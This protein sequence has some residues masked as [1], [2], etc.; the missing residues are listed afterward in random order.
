M[1]TSRNR[2]RHNPNRFANAPR[3]GLQNA[4]FIV[5]LDAQQKENLS[6]WVF[7]YLSHIPSHEKRQLMREL[8]RDDLKEICQRAQPGIASPQHLTEA[9]KLALI[10][11]AIP[12]LDQHLVSNYL[13]ALKSDLEKHFGIGS[14]ETPTDAQFFDFI[15]YLRS[16][17]SRAAVNALISNV[18][19][20]P[21]PAQGYAVEEMEK[22]EKIRESGNEANLGEIEFP[23]MA[24][25]LG[26][27]EI[28]SVGDEKLESD[29]N[30]NDVNVESVE[31]IAQPEHIED[32]N[33]ENSTN[34]VVSEFEE[35]QSI[36]EVN[37]PLV[38]EVEV[39]DI[40]DLIYTPLG[41]LLISQAI[42]SADGRQLGA[43]SPED[44]ALMLEEFASLN[45]NH[46]PT[47]FQAGFSSA[48]G[49]V[50]KDFLIDSKAT[51]DWRKQY[52]LWGYIKG[53]SRANRTT[54]IREICQT[55]W[56][57]IIEMFRL[58]IG[59][60]LFEDVAREVIYANLDY[61]EELL[62]LSHRGSIRTVEHEINL[63]QMLD[64]ESVKMLRNSEAPRAAAILR[65]AERRLK[66]IL[67]QPDLTPAL[68]RAVSNLGLGLRMGLAASYR[69]VGDFANA[70]QVLSQT[71]DEQL[72]LSA[73]RNQSRYFIQRALTESDTKRIE[74][75]LLPRTTQERIAFARRFEPVLGHIDRAVKSTH[76]NPDARYLY[77]GIALAKEDYE[78]ASSLLGQTRLGYE[79]R[80]D[81]QLLIPQLRLQ[82]AILNF[83]LQNYSGI[84]ESINELINN[85][86]SWKLRAEEASLIVRV[87]LETMPNELPRLLDWLTSQPDGAALLTK[88]ELERVFQSLPS[89]SKQVARL[90][91]RI[92]NQVDRLAILLPI[93]EDALIRSH[94]EDL[95]FIL[96]EI[97]ELRNRQ[98]TEAHRM[99]A[100]F[101]R[102]NKYFRDY[103]G[104]FEAN[105]SAIS[106]LSLIPD[107][108]DLV[109]VL[110]SVLD[111]MLPITNFED[112]A[113]FSQLLSQLSSVAPEY[114]NI[115]EEDPRAAAPA[116][117]T[118]WEKSQAASDARESTPV[119]ILFVGGNPERQSE[120]NTNARSEIESKF[121][122]KVELD[123][124]IPGWGS[125]WM[126]V[127]QRIEQ[128][129]SK[130]DAVVLMPL[131]RT[132]FGQTL[133]RKL[134]DAHVPRIS[135]TAEGKTSSVR[136]IEEAVNIAR[137]LR[138]E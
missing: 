10:E 31:E 50:P 73:S 104:K 62:S 116:T 126:D 63:L 29:L 109:Q 24:D 33:F 21:V 131:T 60:D 124:Q 7:E 45:T 129:L 3:Q 2:P 103:L 79:D 136:A 91:H 55:E 125:N 112:E 102:S 30:A 5:E 78:G 68:T 110:I 12:K 41:R 38:D 53:L 19:L 37:D 75:V 80:D 61:A 16:H 81:R 58:N 111:E 54:E 42:S 113:N 14:I 64:T 11:Q 97:D 105:V 34:H 94:A 106:S 51:N 28:V 56:P 99:W 40:S 138:G 120:I 82:Q 98:S 35:I 90:S 48:L 89:C 32:D 59:I 87:T 96:G 133:R 22:I 65:L 6:R 15:T 108:S 23:L 114:V 115:Y 67:A 1:S 93:L 77:A 86:Y 100:E 83:H 69:I 72:S 76:P 85:P 46:R 74:D 118:R 101:C 57:L 8:T 39:P 121:G 36:I 119:R 128:K 43:L 84:Y 9:R 117:Y 26:A 25:S 134:N 123:F 4:D 107:T 130:V 132:T 20:S 135:C 47:W 27:P 49:L 122:S 127:I 44:Y 88:N 137:R 92:S 52:Y 18:A 70:K 17:W 71:P 66:F 95:E 13:R